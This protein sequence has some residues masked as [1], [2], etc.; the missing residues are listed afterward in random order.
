MSVVIELIPWPDKPVRRVSVN[1]FGYGGANGHCIIDHAESII[2]GYELRGLKLRSSQTETSTRINGD[3]AHLEC[4]KSAENHNGVLTVAENVVSKQPSS[5]GTAGSN[6][7]ME[8]RLDSDTK[9]CIHRNVTGEN[10]N[11]ARRY[12]SNGNASHSE[13]LSDN[14]TETDVK[15]CLYNSTERSAMPLI[16]LEISDT[17][18]AIRNAPSHRL[19]LLPVSGHN[20]NSL[21]ANIQSTTEAINEYVLADATYTLTHGRSMFSYRAFAIAETVTESLA[22]HESSFTRGK[23]AGSNLRRIGFIFTG[24][25]PGD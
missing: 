4:E 2:P 13:S 16:G 20:E 14:I 17:L 15:Y 12:E 11:K 19:V 22:I 25:R 7:H 10:S 8:V 24:K 5:N 21:E 6:G 1:S 9:E 3:I 18:L 23:N